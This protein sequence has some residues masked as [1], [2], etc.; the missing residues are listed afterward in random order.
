MP[1]GYSKP[2]SLRSLLI[3]RNN[4][5]SLSDR[6]VIARQL[7]K[8]VGY[9]HT[10][11]FVHKNVRPDNILML[12]PREGS[13]E[14]AYLVGFEQIRTAEGVTSGVGDTAWERNLYRHPHRQGGKPE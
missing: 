13:M 14:H 4:D 2:R 12:Q 5:H 7:A 1:D 3:E 10:F 8:S 9:I 6:F 11:G